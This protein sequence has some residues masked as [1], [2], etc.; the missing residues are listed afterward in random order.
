[1]ADLEE[2]LDGKTDVAEAQPEL[3]EEAIKAEVE[4]KELEPAPKPEKTVAKEEPATVP[5][6][7]V[8]ELRREIRELRQAA[9]P[10]TPPP[11]FL[12]PD[13]AAYLQD[14][15]KNITQNAR[16]DVSEEMARQQFGDDV[17]DAAFAAFQAHPDPTRQ[18]A[19]MAARSPWV[20]L[21]KDHQRQQLVQEIGN[22]PAAY[23]A[24]VE[25]EMRA[26]IEAEMVA[27]QA[28]ARAGSPAP[29]IANVT[30]TGGG[31]NTTWAG[32][33]DLRRALGE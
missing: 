27:K 31:P 16:L 9:Q 23:K 1:M 17:V 29:S 10:K 21:V 30:G 13:G 14:Q 25:A 28:A 4:A 19:I 15:I 7:V 6:A 3:V 22:D 8:Q 33:T 18:R 5:V 24:R 11:D 32:P 26:K 20:E 12:D 2:I